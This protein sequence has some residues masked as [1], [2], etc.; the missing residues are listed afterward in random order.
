[1]EAASRI[2][3]LKYKRKFYNLC[4]A[5]VEFAVDPEGDSYEFMETVM[6]CSGK[7]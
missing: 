2:W 4:E 3:D 7:C 1:M 5:E 6:D